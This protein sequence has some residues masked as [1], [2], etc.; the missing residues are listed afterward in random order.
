M[1][2]PK[3]KQ[4]EFTSESV[5][6]LFQGILNEA[7]ELKLKAI[8][9]FNKQNRDVKD[10]Q[11]INLVGKIN[12]DYLKLYGDAIEKK[13]AVGRL[14]KDIVFKDS[15][16]KDAD[17]SRESLISSEDREAI[18]R[19]MKDQAEKDEIEFVLPKEVEESSEIGDTDNDMPF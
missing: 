9:Q 10:N 2:R 7:D 16:N 4:V 1:P 14:L 18:F 19:A 5:R 6:D 13:I 8:F 3:R 15:G 11:D 17:T 12:A